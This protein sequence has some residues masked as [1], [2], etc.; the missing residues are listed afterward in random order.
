MNRMTHRFALASLVLLAASAECAAQ[1][2]LLFYR[3][4]SYPDLTRR[5]ENIFRINADGTDLR[6][7]TPT[8]DGNINIQATWSPHGT[9]VAYALH[10]RSTGRA[11][12]YVMTNN[13]TGRRRVTSGTG[14]YDRPAWRPDGGR[15]AFIARH[16]TRSCVATV[17]PDG[18][19]QRNVFCVPSPWFIDT[20]PQW[21]GDSTR[22]FVAIES[23]GSGLEP[24]SYS[25]AYRVNASTGAATL[26]TS[27]VFEEYRPFLFSPDGSSGLYMD[28]QEGPMHTV[29]FATDVLTPVTSGF[30]PVYSKSGTRI[31]FSRTQFGDGPELSSFA[32]L[33]VIN[34]DGTGEHQVTHTT[35]NDVEYTAAEWSRFNTHLLVNRTQYMPSSPGSGIYVGTTRMRVIRVATGAGNWLP[36]GVA[37]DWYQGP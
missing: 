28:G 36:Q 25:R 14:D 32:N 1:S 30:G 11:D 7:L 16:A 31:A 15:I 26:L 17:R 20:G 4:A 33:F 19:D 18:V 29:D 13:G 37:G 3:G 34:V 9:Y 12:I 8:V 24:P 2:R 35:A 27:Q 6:Q 22:L 5:Y 23:S 10:M 21:S